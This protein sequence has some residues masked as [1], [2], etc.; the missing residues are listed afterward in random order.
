MLISFCKAI[1]RSRWVVARR[2]RASACCSR[3]SG[4]ANSLASASTSHYVN[5]A[6]LQL[7]AIKEK[8][9]SEN[10]FIAIDVETANSWFGSICQIGVVEFAGG[11]IVQEWETLVDPEGDFL[12]FNV[13]IHKI[14]P[15]MVTGQPLFAGALEQVKQIAG[16]SLI[17][18]YGHFDRSAFSQACHTRSLTNIANP[19]I[20]IH[21]VVK[22]AWPEKYVDGGYRLNSVCKYLGIPLPRHHNA[23]DDARAAGLILSR[24]CE[25]TGIAAVE[26]ISKNRRSLHTATAAKLEIAVNQDGPLAGESIV[27]TGALQMPRQQ[28]QAL[29]AAIGCAPTNSVTKKTTILVVGDQDLT[30]FGGKDK[31]SKHVKAEELMESGQDIQIIGESDFL[32]MIAIDDA[33]QSP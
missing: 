24:A 9:M 26:W 10:H 14:T 29:A 4:P 31:S 33:D 23:V 18:S 28:A 6:K 20:N 17:A 16:E 30:R 5:C 22:R 11:Q 3:S 12:D 19:W 7:P 1:D 27:F 21:S 32:A 2:G 13:R 15:E 25:T 8:A